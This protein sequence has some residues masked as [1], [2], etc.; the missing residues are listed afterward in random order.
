MVLAVRWEMGRVVVKQHDSTVT[1]L[2]NAF[3]NSAEH[4]GVYCLVCHYKRFN[5]VLEGDGSDN[6][7]PIGCS[8]LQW[9]C[10]VCVFIG[11][12]WLWQCQRGEVTFVYPD[13]PFLELPGGGHRCFGSFKLWNILEQQVSWA[14][15]VNFCF[16]SSFHFYSMDSVPH[17]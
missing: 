11:P 4:S 15:D 3:G 13:D 16:C 10:D 9:Q 14:V 17:S 5:T 2:K 8:R 6:T 12:R 7:H 1:M